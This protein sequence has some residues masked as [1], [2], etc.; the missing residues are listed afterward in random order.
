MQGSHAA[1]RLRGS[2]HL[3]SPR[4]KPW[5]F[6]KS[7]RIKSIFNMHRL[8]LSKG[9]LKQDHSPANIL[10]ANKMKFEWTCDSASG[11]AIRLSN[12]RRILC[13][14]L[15]GNR[16]KNLSLASFAQL[17]SPVLPVCEGAGGVS[18]VPQTWQ[19]KTCIC[20][21]VSPTETMWLPSAFW[22]F[23]TGR[24]AEIPASFCSTCFLPLLFLPGTP[25]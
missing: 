3:S 18:A 11:Q 16:D 21:P 6:F 14:R 25:K 1:E 17:Q 19:L 7:S 20:S 4:T 24:T 12:W 2:Q 23:P 15:L 5:V 22:I 13:Y 8:F 10:C 9:Q